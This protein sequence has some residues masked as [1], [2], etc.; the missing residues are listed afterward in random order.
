MERSETKIAERVKF[1]EEQDEIN[2]EII[3]R[4]IKNHELINELNVQLDNYSNIVINLKEEIETLKTHNKLLKENM[5]EIQKTE[6]TNK[7]NVPIIISLL[8]LIISFLAII[9]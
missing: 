1:W 6:K 7:G 5:Q 3:P 2:K 9:M 4:V 8:A